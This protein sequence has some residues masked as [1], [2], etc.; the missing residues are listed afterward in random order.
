MNTLSLLGRVR[1]TGDPRPNPANY[2]LVGA[3]VGWH[4]TVWQ[5][6]DL[7]VRFGVKNLANSGAREPDSTPQGIY[8]DIP[9]PGRELYATVAFHY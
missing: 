8:Y 6:S 1:P 2:T 9:L 5:G 3:D 7:V 4:H